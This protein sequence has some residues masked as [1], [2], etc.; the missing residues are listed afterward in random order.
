MKSNWWLGFR[1]LLFLSEQLNETFLV[2]ILNFS[3]SDDGVICGI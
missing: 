2:E 3:I 1:L